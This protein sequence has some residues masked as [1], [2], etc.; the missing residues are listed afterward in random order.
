MPACV[1][2]I[3]LGLA[4][5]PAAIAAPTVRPAESTAATGTITALEGDELTIQTGGREMSVIAAMT[6]AANTI[7]RHDYPYVYAG[8]H[9]QAGTASVGMRGTGYN[10]RRIG[11]DCSGSVAAVL[12]GGGIWQAGSGVPSDAGIVAQLRQE[13]L[14]AR[15]A[16]S[17]PQQV[18]LYDD[19]GVHIFM[20]IDGRFFGTSDGGGDPPRRLGGPA[21]L[22]DGAPDAYSRR[23][24]SWHLLPAALG[25]R[26][27]YGPSVSFQID[28]PSLLSTYAVGERVRVGY[29]S[30][31]VGV[32]V[33]KAVQLVGVRSLSGTV[34]VISPDGS[35]LIL[36]TAGGKSITLATAVPAVVEGVQVGDAVQVS[37]VKA[38][39]GALTAESIAVT[40]TPSAPV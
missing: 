30:N 7:N 9:A 5:A 32:N 26:T 23:Y 34:S 12:A 21:W 13:R 15:G 35:S 38:P 31:R 28:D 20:S 37:Y 6:A 19:W 39:G 2:P 24:R 40:G 3:V 8:G 33:A 4:L 18:T 22:N 25:H 10:G 14:I 1:L 16:G 36:T 11:Y 29:V 17:G 27:T